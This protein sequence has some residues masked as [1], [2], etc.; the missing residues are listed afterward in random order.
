M[1]MGIAVIMRQLLRFPCSARSLNEV[2][3]ALKKVEQM[4]YLVKT[5]EVG[6]GPRHVCS[7]YSVVSIQSSNN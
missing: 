1:R 4:E 7:L 5:V 2:L 3:Q 6:G